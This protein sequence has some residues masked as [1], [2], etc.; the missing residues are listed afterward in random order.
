M[1]FKV[2]NHLAGPAGNKYPARPCKTSPKEQAL[3]CMFWLGFRDLI[4]NP[5][6]YIIYLNSF[7]VETSKTILEAHGHGMNI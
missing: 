1:P 3:L 5:S 2:E 7:D 6:K 4:L